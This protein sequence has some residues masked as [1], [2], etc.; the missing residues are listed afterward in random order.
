[1]LF[2]TDK[3]TLDDLNIFGKQDSNS[4]YG[5]FNRGKGLPPKIIRPD[6]RYIFQ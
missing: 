3:Q 6:K 4:I 1:M 5:I 2:N